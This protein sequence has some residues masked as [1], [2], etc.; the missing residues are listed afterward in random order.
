MPEY[1]QIFNKLIPLFL[2][3]LQFNILPDKG[4]VIGKTNHEIFW[5]MRKL[6]FL[7]ILGTFCP[8]MTKP[9]FFFFFN[10]FRQFLDSTITNNKPKSE[11]NYPI[12]RKRESNIPT[13][14]LALIQWPIIFLS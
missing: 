4:F 8:S 5:K 3:I 9:R 14:E 13:D 7:D 12:L 11:K 6:N 10:V 1:M 2:E